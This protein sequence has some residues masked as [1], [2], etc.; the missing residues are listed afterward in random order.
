MARFTI[1]GLTIGERWE[2][3]MVETDE[4][5]FLELAQHQ[6]DL[7]KKLE[8]AAE[9]I[10]EHLLKL[11]YYG[12]AMPDTVH[13]WKNSVYNKLISIKPR[14]GHGMRFPSKEFIFNHTWG[15]VKD[16]FR[17]TCTLLPRDLSGEYHV[18]RSAARGADYDKLE[19]CVIEYF[20][21]LSDG[22]SQ[23]HTFIYNE[24]SDE[25]DELFKDC[26]CRESAYGSDV[27]QA[28]GAL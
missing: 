19:D 25:I 20:D 16:R 18:K 23:G 12:D 3:F 6:G 2:D 24:V 17:T 21:W 4:R 14:K 26:H 22:L 8:G 10:V 9:V 27:W 28:G 5:R 15:A 13:N 7:P 1:G 11:Y